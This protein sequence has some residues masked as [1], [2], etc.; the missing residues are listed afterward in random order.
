MDKVQT[1]GPVKQTKGAGKETAAGAAKVG[2][3]RSAKKALGKGRG[4]IGGK[5]DK[6]SNDFST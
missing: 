2:A 1:K 5:K 3:R 6:L 4:V